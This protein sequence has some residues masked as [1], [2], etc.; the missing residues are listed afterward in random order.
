[1]YSIC[2]AFVWTVKKHL[3]LM[4]NFSDQ[5]IILIRL[6]F[7]KTQVFDFIQGHFLVPQISLSSRL[8]ATEACSLVLFF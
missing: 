2:K 3:A 7:I 4:E 5:L 8:K 1:M 6:F